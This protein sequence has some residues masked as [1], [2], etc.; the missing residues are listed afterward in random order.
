[1]KP[2]KSQII[3]YRERSSR[4]WE[5]ETAPLELR[6]PKVI[7]TDINFQLQFGPHENETYARDKTSK[8]HHNQ[9]M[10]AKTIDNSKYPFQWI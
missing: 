6:M 5:I 3:W 7:N 9:S 1:M 2:T 10:D 8:H 4:G